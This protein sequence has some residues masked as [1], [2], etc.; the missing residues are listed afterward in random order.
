LSEEQE[1]TIAEIVQEEQS[2]IVEDYA[3]FF[4]HWPQ[5]RTARV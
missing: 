3:E 4:V 5:V 1:G 2:D